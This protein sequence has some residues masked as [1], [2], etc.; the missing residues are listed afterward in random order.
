MK[1]A[2]TRL[3]R[4][5]TISTSPTLSV[6]RIGGQEHLEAQQRIERDV[7]QQARQHRRDRRRA[8]GMG[9]GQPGVQRREADLGAVAD[10]QE[11]EGERQQLGIELAGVL[12]HQ[13]P[14]HRRQPLA[15]HLLGREIDEDG[16][17]E[18][19]RD[20]DRTEDEVFPRR[21]DRLR[22]AIDADH[23][24][25]RK[26]RDL[27][28]D[29]EQADVVGDERHIHRAD[30]RL[31]QRVIE[32]QERRRQP[33]GLE[34]MA[35]IARAE[36]RRGEGDEGGQRDEIDVEIVDDQDVAAVAVGRTAATRPP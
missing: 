30:H 32:A 8:F 12:R 27:D 31:V 4:P 7:E 33:A 24:H 18:G 11:D 5:S 22:R 10:Q 19:Q 23:H 14:G 16:A 35:D 21:L 15:Q 2:N 17:E 25:G 9:V 6:V 34:L 1:A 36:D 26:R 3:T 13:I 29:P 20:A 28:A